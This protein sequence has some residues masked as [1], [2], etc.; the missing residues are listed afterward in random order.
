MGSVHH[1]EYCVAASIEPPFLQSRLQAAPAPFCR[2]QS[3]D[4]GWCFSQ[5]RHRKVSQ[6]TKFVDVRFTS[7]HPAC[8]RSPKPKH[9]RAWLAADSPCVLKASVAFCRNHVIVSILSFLGLAP[10]G[11]TEVHEMLYKTAISLVEGGETGVFTPMHLLFCRK[12]ET[13]EAPV[14]A[15]SA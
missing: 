13:A 5:V 1:T 14:A 10:A 7:T 12:P 15:A 2:A 8:T 11:T 3:K 6:L 9:N 4:R